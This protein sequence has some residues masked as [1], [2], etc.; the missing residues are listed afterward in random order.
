MDLPPLTAAMRSHR[1]VTSFEA[2]ARADGLDEE[3]KRV[4]GHVE[5]AGPLAEMDAETRVGILAAVA[6]PEDPCFLR[7]G[8][9][10]TYD[11]G[12]SCSYEYVGLVVPE[13]FAPPTDAT[14]D[15]PATIEEFSP[16]PGVKSHTRTTSPVG[17]TT[18]GY[19]RKTVVG[20]VVLYTPLG[21]LDA[22]QQESLDAA[23]EVADCGGFRVLHVQ[24]DYSGDVRKRIDYRVELEEVTYGAPLCP[25][26]QTARG[27]PTPASTSAS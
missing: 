24:S 25:E 13:G 5:F 16:T 14:W 27:S 7:T 3:T 11:N 12:L 20:C 17:V 19:R 22:K 4:T 2:T 1:R 23:C 26:K 8:G 21:R 6:C 10:V 15:D 18:E 9:R